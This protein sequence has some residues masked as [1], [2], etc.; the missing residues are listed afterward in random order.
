MNSFLAANE[1]Y[2]TIIITINNNLYKLYL[3]LLVNI[4]I[5]NDNNS[6]HLYSAFLGTQIVFP[7]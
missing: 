4:Q 3:S 7:L 6:I 1:I 5:C 2:K